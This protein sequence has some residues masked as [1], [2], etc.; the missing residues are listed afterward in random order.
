MGDD[1]AAQ[2]YE[3]G[4]C[5]RSFKAVA[6][7]GYQV[8]RPIVDRGVSRTLSSFVAEDVFYAFFLYVSNNLC[9]RV[10]SVLSP[11]DRQ[12]GVRRQVD[13][14]RLVGSKYFLALA[15]VNDGEF[16][17]VSGIDGNVRYVFSVV[18]GYG[19][20]VRFL[21]EIRCFVVV[22]EDLASVPRL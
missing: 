12:V 19:V 6:G 11:G 16:I 8:L 20:P 2:E 3:D 13:V 22:P 5:K 14:C 17:L 1:G 7:V 21:Q 18:N 4:P 10:L 15:R 9:L